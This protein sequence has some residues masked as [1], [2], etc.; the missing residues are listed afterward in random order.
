[1]A[2]FE[3]KLLRD[4]T[5]VEKDEKK[6]SDDEFKSAM[7]TAARDRGPDLR[8]A[9]NDA[10]PKPDAVADNSDWR[11]A[12]HQMDMRDR[13]NPVK[14][15][16]QIGGKIDEFVDPASAKPINYAPGTEPGA[17][18]PYGITAHSNALAAAR[19]APPPQPAAPAPELRMP[20]YRPPTTVAA[21]WDPT[22]DPERASTR[23]AERANVVSTLAA[24]EAVNKA[25]QM[26]ATI[27]ADGLEGAYQDAEN[28]R[29]DRMAGEMK[30]QAYMD[31]QRSKVDRITQDVAESKIDPGR[32]YGDVDTGTRIA[33]AIGGMFGGMSAALNGGENHFL[34]TIQGNIDRD[35]DAQ[36]EALGNKKFAASQAKG[37]LG[38]LRQDF[39][40]D[41]TAELVNEKAAWQNVMTQIDSQMAR[42]DGA[43][44]QAEGLKMKAVAEGK[45]IGIQAE[46]DRNTHVNSYTYGGG[47]AGTSK[48]NPLA[49]HLPNGQV[50]IA[51]TEE[52]ARKMRGRAGILEKQRVIDEKALRLRREI[53]NNPTSGSMA[54]YKELQGLQE[55]SASLW[56]TG[57]EQGVLKDA[58][59]ERAVKRVAD[60]TNM[61]PFTYGDTDK[62][63]SATA[64][65][66]DKEFEAELNAVAP[67]G[68]V[69]GHRVDANGQIQPTTEYDGTTSAPI[70]RPKTG[71]PIGQ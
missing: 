70:R 12:F 28:R 40:D 52:E 17:P 25:R 54:K 33:I 14:A 53:A 31:E 18:D 22:R 21:H 37:M 66:R 5:S 30:R 59:Y 16:S 55:D 67:E 10:A 45:L 4:E 13:L 24:D 42:A 3:D 50:R 7:S 44:M 60:Y 1:M 36:K 38:E 27:H 65:R 9:Q 58:E 8:L 63:L 51:S 57:V 61:N 68:G 47:G 64:E 43:G 39:G 23:N 46:I 19:N 41:R 56:S 71:K 11:T 15:L 35:I 26:Q 20:A 32:L 29:V 69:T 49:I 34:K 62:A 2:T 48:T 6:L